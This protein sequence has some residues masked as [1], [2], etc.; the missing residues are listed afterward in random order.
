MERMTLKD[1]EVKMLSEIVKNSRR[2]D[3]ELAKAIGTS[4]PTA[5]RIRAK[6][7]KEGYIKEYTAI[8]D[9]I[10]I[11]H[12]IMALTFLK[13]D[14]KTA[15]VQN[16]YEFKKSHFEAISQDSTAA[17]L[18][19]KQGLGLGYDKVLISFHPN[20]AAFDKFQLYVKEKMGA[21]L[22]D[23]NA[24]LINLVDEKNNLP[25][26]FKLLANQIRASSEKEKTAPSTQLKK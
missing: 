8:P 21:N 25:F 26:T 11:G 5:T 20:Y 22:L 2:S 15:V 1:L 3:R 16:D 17:V 7:E 18:L 13:F 24:F 14:Q 23:V 12:T 10:K 6:L 19:A 4:Q 9:L